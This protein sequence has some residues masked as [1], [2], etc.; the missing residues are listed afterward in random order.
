MDRPSRHS[1]RV[2]ERPEVDPMGAAEAVQ[3][4]FED[5]V[6]M[7]DRQLDNLK[8]KDSGARLHVAKAKAAAERGLQLSRA[9]LDTLGR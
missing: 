6:A 2:K 3:R 7:F 1:S 9:L 4:D 8:G 5:L